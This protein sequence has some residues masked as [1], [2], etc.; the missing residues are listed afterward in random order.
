MGVDYYAYAFI[1]QKINKNKLNKE[2][3]VPGCKHDN[4]KTA[5]FCST[6]G[7]RAFITDERPVVDF[8]EIGLTVINTTDDRDIF[9]ALPQHVVKTNSSRSMSDEGD[10]GHITL[11]INA[12]EIAQM[13][14]Q[15]RLEPHG[16]WDK[17]AFGLWTTQYCSY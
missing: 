1:G 8:D 6:C 9:V 2:V 12:I 10:Q 3:T 11:A 4:P 17:Q 15:K 16:L 13:E 14:L 5:T 7:K